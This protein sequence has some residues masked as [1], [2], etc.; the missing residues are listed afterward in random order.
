MHQLED[1][2]FSTKCDLCD[3]PIHKDEN[4]VKISEKAA[5]TNE[6]SKEKGLEIKVVPEQ[7]THTKYAHTFTKQVAKNLDKKVTSVFNLQH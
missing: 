3:L 7:D 4:V 5:N 1:G 2:D 6:P